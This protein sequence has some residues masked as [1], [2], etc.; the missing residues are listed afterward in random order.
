MESNTLVFT[1]KI[2]NVFFYLILGKRNLFSPK[3][4]T[5][6]KYSNAGEFGS[7]IFGNWNI[8]EEI[9]LILSDRANKGQKSHQLEMGLSLKYLPT[10]HFSVQL[11]Q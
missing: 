1:S 7:E 6:S 4:A 9:K 2:V 11:M 10:G 3:A 5:K 8:D